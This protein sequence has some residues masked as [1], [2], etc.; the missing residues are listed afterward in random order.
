ML[1]GKPLDYVPKASVSAAYTTTRAEGE[2][3]IQ[4]AVRAGRDTRLKL[5]AKG[6]LWELLTYH[7]GELPSDEDI[8]ESHRQS[9]EAEGQRADGLD[10]I[11]GGLN[12]L[13]RLGYL[14]RLQIR[15]QAGRKRSVRAL[16]DSPG[17]HKLD[18]KTAYDDAQ[19]LIRKAERLSAERELL[20][21]QEFPRLA[22]CPPAD[23]L[24][25]ARD[26]VISLDDRRLNRAG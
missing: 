6:L 21:Q 18:I 5:A 26:N 7:D 4:L 12:D 13:E 16:T 14:V 3:F 11:R 22:H 19:H 1:P 25:T 24:G 8:Y 9:R 15:D 17:H 10:V 23:S 20:V 2:I